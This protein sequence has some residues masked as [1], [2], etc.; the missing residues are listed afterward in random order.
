[1]ISLAGIQF[2]FLW[3]KGIR[4]AM[5]TWNIAPTVTESFLSID[6]NP[7]VVTD[8]DILYDPTSELS[9][10]DAVR[11]ELFAKGTDPLN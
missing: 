9:S 1:M 2:S 8:E 7:S 5:K 3:G 11:L 6:K 10:V 4:S